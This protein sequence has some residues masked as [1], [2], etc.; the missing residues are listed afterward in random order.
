MFDR[1]GRV[2]RRVMKEK[3]LG[4]KERCVCVR[5]ASVKSEKAPNRLGEPLGGS[6]VISGSML[7]SEFGK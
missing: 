5:K 1:V 4:D 3:Q 6:R 7:N 2:R